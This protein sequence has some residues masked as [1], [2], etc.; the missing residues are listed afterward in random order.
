VIIIVKM[1]KIII[2]Y[3]NSFFPGNIAILYQLR[4]GK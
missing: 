3:I 2:F 4:V 1:Q